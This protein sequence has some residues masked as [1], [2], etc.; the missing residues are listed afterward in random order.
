MRSRFV[1][2]TDAHVPIVATQGA[3]V[4]FVVCSRSSGTESGCPPPRNFSSATAATYP[5]RH[6]QNP[7]SKA[8]GDNTFCRTSKLATSSQSTSCCK[9]VQKSDNSYSPVIT[10]S[11]S[12]YSRP[13][14]LLLRHFR[15]SL[16][17]YS[18]VIA[19]HQTSSTPQ[20]PPQEI[21]NQRLTNLASRV[22]KPHSIIYICPL[23]VKPE[24]AHS[25]PASFSDQVAVQPKAADELSSRRNFLSQQTPLSSSALTQVTVT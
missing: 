23:C 12:F 1:F 18:P 3:S 25:A 4:R 5:N 14:C 19:A 10:F 22:P 15:D 21:A 7:T 16:W 24:S 9:L 8:I 17:C 6:A 20:N 11:F 2:A 13:G